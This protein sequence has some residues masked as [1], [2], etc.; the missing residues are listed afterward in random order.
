MSKGLDRRLAALA[1]AVELADGRLDGAAVDAARAVVQRAGHRLGLGLETT[2]VALA[3]PTGAGKSSLFNALAGSELV[4]AGRMRPTTSSATAVVWGDGAGPLLDWLE[5]PVRHDA[6]DAGR[7]GPGDLVLLD[8]PDFDS[9]ERRHRDEVDRVVELVDLVVWVVD[10]QKYADATLHDGYLKPLSEYRDSMVVVLNQADTL[11]PAALEACRRDLARQLGA[12]GLEGVPVLPVSAL[13]GAGVGELRDLLEQRVQRREAALHRL[14]ADVSRTAA[15]LGASCGGQA[16]GKLSSDDVGRLLVALEQAAGV[17][18]VV[19]ATGAAHRR[20]GALSA[21]WPPTRWLRRV[22]P[23]PLRRLHL[24]EGPQADVRTSLPPASPVQRSQVASAIRVLAAGASRELPEPWPSLARSAAVG[25]ESDLADRLDRA[26]A[27]A[28]LAR[29][30]PLWWKAAAALQLLLILVVALGALWL[31]GYGILGYLQVSDL[32][33]TPEVEGIPLPT[34]M[35]AGGALA[36]LLLALL[37]RVVNSFGSRRRERRAQRTLRAG[38]RAVA[39][40][41]VLD[42]L[43]RELATYGKLCSEVE[44]ASGARRR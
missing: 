32:V 31:L 4:T 38:V 3:G 10:P 7:R 21:G 34:V 18:A 20:R 5:V 43:E 36:G 12:D 23:D 19:R 40:E 42:P 11:E 29:R 17:P 1:A 9:V 33:P 35:L 22:R 8:L 6:G 2:A 15:G 25:R 44:A 37:A 41:L 30:E 13:T 26:V 39:T 16:R 14:A 24:G 28:G 27:G